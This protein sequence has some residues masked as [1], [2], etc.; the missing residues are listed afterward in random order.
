MPGK[1]GSTSI[2][3]AYDDGPG[4]TARTI[5]SGVLEMSG[6]KITSGMQVSTAYGDT[7]QKKLPTGV[8]ELAEMT[9]R[10]FWDTTA[11][12]GSHA[13]FKDPDDG[14]QDATRT[15]TVVFGDSKTWT[16]E[17]YLVSYEVIG[18]AGNLTEFVAVLQQNSG[19]WS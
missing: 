5:T 11:T 7:V 8:L 10:G 1:Y 15:L 17:G 16:S 12:T 2:T 13:V 9:L 19:S 6:V 14:P 3:I 18:K 4:G